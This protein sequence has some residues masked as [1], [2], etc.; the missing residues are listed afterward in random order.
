MKLEIITQPTGTDIVSLNDAKE[1]LRVDHTDEDTTITRLINAAVQHCQDYTGR[2]F[3]ASNFNLYLDDFYNCEFSTSPINSIS[4]VK[5][6]NASNELTTLATSKYWVDDKRE[7]GRIHFDNP[8]DVYD[9]RF[10]GVIIA[11]SLGEAPATPIIHAVRMLVAH[12]YE[13]RRAVITGTTS[14]ETPLGV[15]ALLNPYRVIYTK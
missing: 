15:A 4:S 13:N 6:Y 11:G 7:P 2:H 10:N 1:F 12:Y 8:P 14:I 9:D 3:V 5:Y